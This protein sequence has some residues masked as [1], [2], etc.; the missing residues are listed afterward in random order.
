MDSKD[1]ETLKRFLDEDGKIIITEDMPD[2]LKNAINYMNENNINLLEKRQHVS[3]DDE[4]LDEDY[5]DSDDES[6][7][8]SSDVVIEDDEAD[9]SDSLNDNL[10]DEADESS[11]QDLDNLF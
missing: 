8:I 10:S 1:K 11:L 4:D 6:Y 5:D 2:D 7:D 3:F 9:D